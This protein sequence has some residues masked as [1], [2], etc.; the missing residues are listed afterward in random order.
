MLAKYPSI[1]E[2]LT[3]LGLGKRKMSFFTSVRYSDAVSAAGPTPHDPPTSYVVA[4]TGSS[5]GAFPPAKGKT[6]GWGGDAEG[7]TP[8]GGGPGEWPPRSKNQR[9]RAP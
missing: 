4:I 1:V 2:P 7:S 6:Q 9:R 3:G 8:P 5:G